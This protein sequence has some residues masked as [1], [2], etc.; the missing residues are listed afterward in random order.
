M[1]EFTRTFVDSADD[2]LTEAIVSFEEARDGGLAPDPLDWLNRFSDVAERLRAYFV[3]S[4]NLRGL[5]RAADAEFPDLGA[6]ADYD[7]LELISKGGM[8]VVYK[9][10]RKSTQQIVALKLIRPDLLQGLSP[11]RRRKILERFITEAQVAAL[12]EHENIVKVY[13]VGEG[14]G[15]P[16]YSMRYVQGKSLSELLQGGIIPPEQAAAYIEQIARAV[17]LAHQHGIIHRDLK[18]NNILVDAQTD[19]P[20]V[21][22][23]GLAKLMDSNQD[24]TQTRD[25]MGTPPYMSPEQA[26]NSAHVTTATDVYGLGAT[27]YALLT[28]RPPFEGDTPVATLMKVRDENPP[29]PRQANP[30][31]PRDLETICMK[32]LEKDACRRYASALRLAEDLESWRQGMP[33]SARHTGPVEHAWHWCRRNPLVASLLICVTL[34]ILGGVALATYFGIEASISGQRADQNAT[35]AKMN[36]KKAKDAAKKAFVKSYV[37]D[38]QLI[39]R[40]WTGHQYDLIRGL[41]DRQRPIHTD[42][43][44]IRG[45]EWYYWQRVAVPEFSD[46]PDLSEH[47]HATPMI[48]GG[49]WAAWQP[50]DQGNPTRL[51]AFVWDAIA[52]KKTLLNIEQSNPKDAI[53]ALEL[54]KDAQMIAIRNLKSVDV[55]EVSSNK[56]KTSMQT[57]GTVQVMA[58]SPEGGQLAVA[59]TLPNGESEICVYDI[60]TGKPTRTFPLKNR[61]VA[62]LAFSHD[63]NLAAGFANTKRKDEAEPKLKKTSIMPVIVEIWDV[64]SGESIDTFKKA[65]ADVRRMVFHPDNQRILISGTANPRSAIGLPPMELSFFLELWSLK[66]QKINVISNWREDMQFD[67]SPNGATIATISPDSIE[68]FRYFVRVW[69]AVQNTTEKFRIR[70]HSLPIVDVCYGSDSKSLITKDEQGLVKKWSMDRNQASLNFRS[71]HC[72]PMLNSTTDFVTVVDDNTIR[73]W[74]RRT[75]EQ[76]GP[77]IRIRWEGDDAPKGFVISPDG[78]FV[79]T[80]FREHVAVWDTTAGQGGIPLHLAIPREGDALAPIQ[81]SFGTDG[82][83]LLVRRFGNSNPV[84]SQLWD[85]TTGKELRS[86]ATTESSE[87]LAY[88]KDLQ[89][90]V[91]ARTKDKEPILL[92]QFSDDGKQVRGVVG[93][94]NAPTVRTFDPNSGVEIERKMLEVELPNRD[95]S[96]FFSP[97]LV[98]LFIAQSK[99][100]SVI[101][102]NSNRVAFTTAHSAFGHNPVMSQDGRLI[103]CRDKQHVR[104]LET[105][106]GLVVCSFHHEEFHEFKF[107]P[108]GTRVAGIRMLDKKGPRPWSGTRVPS[109]RYEVR[110]WETTYGQELLELGPIN[111][112][113]KKA[114]PSDGVY[115]SNDG[116]QLMLQ[117]DNILR[118]WTL[119]QPGDQ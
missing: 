82:R 109:D 26:Q 23:F 108:C 11:E 58:F 45:I 6:F 33:I 27:L 55:W 76:Q 96:F 91:V 97:D 116:Y 24:L 81:L 61:R 68:N 89:S 14:S 87:A 47:L 39:G 102:V 25:V 36:E 53:N 118:I 103:L 110:V 100:L 112:I 43:I 3:N 117:L 22:D 50:I 95:G 73:V 86:V 98:S 105:G 38:M 114:T 5:T 115:F 57:S 85:V 46:H 101:N 34:S 71:Y 78:R 19:R 40:L 65:N 113:R 56:K 37:S 1:A 15:H 54:S 79:A 69:N 29:R 119:R 41:L 60:N 90:H 104:I 92:V 20:L 28:G 62:C 63:G 72:P 75:N 48:R 32:C 107:S 42:G 35:R 18:P 8:G 64:K 99:T 70:G 16:Y 83:R 51:R 88:T 106:T 52:K 2:R 94:R 30:A 59:S 44:D 84:V 9:A 12:L 77:G 31:V 4:Q 49:H 7:S 21:I 13:D 66:T 111:S 67:I 80:A 10:R 93:P 17:H 74:N